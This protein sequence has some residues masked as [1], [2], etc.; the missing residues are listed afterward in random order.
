MKDIDYTIIISSQRRW[1]PRHSQSSDW[2]DKDIPGWAFTNLLQRLGMFAKNRRKKEIN[3]DKDELY[4]IF[5]DWEVEKRDPFCK[6]F[7]D[8][9]LH[10]KGPK[11]EPYNSG[12]LSQYNFVP[13]LAFTSTLYSPLHQLNDIILYNCKIL[14]DWCLRQ[15]GRGRPHKDFFC[16][17]LSKFDKS[18]S[19][20]ILGYGIVHRPKEDEE[21]LKASLDELRSLC[22]NEGDQFIDELDI[23]GILI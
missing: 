21:T 3:I 8:A 10:G 18:E 5:C 19:G 16:G 2:I 7:Q 17:L 22:S 9:F 6:A 20:E 12:P 13:I 11:D 4:W 15:R 23:L 14:L 1:R